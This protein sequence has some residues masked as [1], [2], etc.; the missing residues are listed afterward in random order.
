MR[1][2]ALVLLALVAVSCS[3]APTMQGSETDGTRKVYGEFSCIRFPGYPTMSDLGD[4]TL[5]MLFDSRE[6]C[7]A[8]VKHDNEML[9]SYG[10][11][12]KKECLEKII[13]AWH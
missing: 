10:D 8:W 3:K 13:P 9:R 4:C 7:T 12:V 5:D 1:K 11:V 2:L 6:E